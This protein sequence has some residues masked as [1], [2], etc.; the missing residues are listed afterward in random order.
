VGGYIAFFSPVGASLPVTNKQPGS[1]GL[2]SYVGDDL[3]LL[4]TEREYG[5]EVFLMI[6]RSPLFRI[7][8]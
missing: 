6:E 2:P 1:S 4:T 3:D 5:F 8:L 7:Y